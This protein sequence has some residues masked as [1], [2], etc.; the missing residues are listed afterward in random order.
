MSK[1]KIQYIISPMQMAF[2]NSIIYKATEP[3][4][5][6]K[7][8]EAFGKIFIESHPEFKLFKKKN[9]DIELDGE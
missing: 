7:K 2:V 3:S 5:S 8:G 9:A 1:K 4:S 6:L